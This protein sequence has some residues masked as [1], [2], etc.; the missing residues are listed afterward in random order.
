[1]MG[2]HPEALSRWG[3]EKAEKLGVWGT[4]SLEGAQ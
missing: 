1:M 3:T 2:D 4:P